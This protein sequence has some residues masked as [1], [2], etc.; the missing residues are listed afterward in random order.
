[1][2]ENHYVDAKDQHIAAEGV[3]D[4]SDLTTFYAEAKKEEL[5]PWMQEADRQKKLEEE[6]NQVVRG[7]RKSAV[8]V[9]LSI[10]LTV[11]VGIALG[12]FFMNFI[13]IENAT[14]AL[15]VIILGLLGFIGLTFV[16][17]RWVIRT[18][19]NHNLRALPITLTTLLSLLFASRPLF[20]SMNTFIGGIAGYCAALSSLIILGII[21][22]SVSIFVWTSQKIHG[23][24]KILILALFFGT[25]VAA[26]YMI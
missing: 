9:G 11:V 15:P 23:I 19:N 5:G 12:Q 13:T 25:A 14:Y 17:L 3:A 24:V 6:R 7:L 16:L 1:M 20:E 10:S 22:A 4:H 8:L 2:A 18:F 21:I 26:V